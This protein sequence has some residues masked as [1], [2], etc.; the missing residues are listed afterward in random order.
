MR[1]CLCAPISVAHRHFQAHDRVHPVLPARFGP[2]HGTAQ[3]VVVGEGDGTHADLGGARDQ[4]L[5]IGRA[6]EEREAAVAVELDVVR[7]HGR[8]GAQRTDAQTH[9]RTE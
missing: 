9:R 1:L 4:R 2:A 5:G 3:V 6:V 8:T 7:R